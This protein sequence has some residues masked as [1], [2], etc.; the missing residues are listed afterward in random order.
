MLD[1]FVGVEYNI[2]L[3]AS[4]SVSR[5]ETSD[6]DIDPRASKCT[7]NS[8]RRILN[9]GLISLLVNW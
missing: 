8:P 2:A 1:R 5:E 7:S 6:H 3:T 4:V 9:I